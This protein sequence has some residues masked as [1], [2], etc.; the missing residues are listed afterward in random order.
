[1]TPKIVAFIITLLA[2][3]VIGVAVFFFM[4]LAMNGFSESDATYGFVAYIAL[5]LII[6]LA[7]SA[8]AAFTVHFLM[9]REFRGAIAALIAVPVFSVVG[10]GL[11]IGCGII[12]V[13]IAEYVRINF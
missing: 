8:A 11:K 6:S 1:M 9:K 10:G 2:N 5:A 12:G 13:L 4:M 7:M 3:V